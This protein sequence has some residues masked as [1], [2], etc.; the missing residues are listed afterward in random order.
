MASALLLREREAATDLNRREAIPRPRS[1]DADTLT[2]EAVIASTTPV[3]RRDAG[4][5]FME[6]LDPAGLDLQ[7]TRGASVLDSHMQGGLDNVLGAIDDVWIEG[8]EVIARIRFS[9]R[10]EVAT[11]VADVRDGIIQFLSVG[12]DIQEVREGKDG[13]GRRTVTAVKWAVREASFVSVPADPAA[14]TRGRDPADNRAAINRQIRELARRANAPQSVVDDL[15]DRDATVE[16]ARGILLFDLLDRGRL[17]IRSTGRDHNAFTLDNPAVLVRAMGEALYTRVAPNTRPSEAARQFV[18]LDNSGSRARALAAGG[19]QTTGMGAD[20]L[21]TRAL[22]TTSDFAL[23]LADTVNR[24]LR[25]L[26]SGRAFGRSPA[27]A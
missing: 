6:I 13:Q 11:V 16:D 20:A 26:I 14:R 2:I 25:S 22:N 4:G 8:N 18:G 24:T 7:T 23:I 21:V 3:R 27:G 10:P 5:E 1:F 17:P 19:F 9:S 15:I 12:Y